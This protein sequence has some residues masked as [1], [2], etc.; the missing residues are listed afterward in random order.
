MSTDGM[1]AYIDNQKERTKLW[2]LISDYSM[3]VEHR[4]INKS[5][6]LSCVPA[7]NNWNLIFK[8]QLLFTLALSKIKYLNTNPTEMYKIYE[9]NYKTDKR[10]QRKIKY[11]VIPYSWIKRLNTTKM[12]VLPNLIYGVNATPTK[13]SVSYFV[14]INKI[15][16]KLCGEAKD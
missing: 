2:E 10:Y 7:M 13:I 15:M 14:V 12:W 4:L 3:V 9:E 16:L 5:H 1:T 11:I 6:L 8:T